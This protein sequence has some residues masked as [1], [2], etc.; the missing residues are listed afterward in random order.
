MSYPF[1]HWVQ[2]HNSTS[3]GRG[4]AGLVAGP[5]LCD[6]LGSCVQLNSEFTDFS[7]ASVLQERKRNISINTLVT[8]SKKLFKYLQI[9]AASNLYQLYSDLFKDFQRILTAGE[10]PCVT[11]DSAPLDVER[12]ITVVS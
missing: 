8:R 10:S 7:H 5:G 4:G 12:E 6:S 1:V 11:Y 2:Y 9:L 3:T